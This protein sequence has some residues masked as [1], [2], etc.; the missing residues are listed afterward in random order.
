MLL[1]AFQ[2]GTYAQADLKKVSINEHL[3]QIR[4]PG[5]RAREAEA[6]ERMIKEARKMARK[7]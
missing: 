1:L 3:E 4:D 6:R 5:K 2:T 7:R